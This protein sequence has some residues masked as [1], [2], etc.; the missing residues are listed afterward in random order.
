MNMD[1]IKDQ[2]IKLTKLYH[3]DAPGGDTQK[4][5]TIRAAFEKVEEEHKR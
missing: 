4:F 1:Q 2:F 3:P 5:I